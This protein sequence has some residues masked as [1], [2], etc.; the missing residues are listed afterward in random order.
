MDDFLDRL[1][2][3]RDLSERGDIRELQRAAERGRLVRVHRGA[4][5]PFERWDK[6]TQTE[7]YTY[8]V[9]GSVGTN[10]VNPTISHVSAAVLH[11]AP[12]IGPMPN[13][14][15]MLATSAAGTRTEHGYRKHATE[16]PDE[17]IES[18]GELRITSL[19]RT[20]ADV[21]TDSPFLTSVGVLDWALGSHAVTATDVLGM[22]ERLE[23]R[24]GRRRAERAIAFADARSGSPGETLSRV[25]M[26]EAGLPAPELQVS[27]ADQAGRI[28][29]VDFWWPDYQ[30]IGEFDGVSKYVRD[31]FTG[32]RDPAQVVVAEKVR[33]DRL[34]A[35]GPAVAR[36][37][38][39][40]AWAPFMLQAQLRGRGLPSSRRRIV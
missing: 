13:L 23:I 37:G 28:G 7:R 25:R 29:V 22:I 27:F 30:L 10:R 38:W 6:L 39:S 2:F 12:I 15:H 5:Y 17:E 31:E 14:V 16:F 4:Y 26:F 21:A 19:L 32:G 9:L 35:L 3:L 18:R 24:R 8:Q 34:R 36:W 11:G 1:Q 20:L 33:E 40:V